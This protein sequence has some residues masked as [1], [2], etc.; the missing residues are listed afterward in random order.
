MTKKFDKDSI[1]ASLFPFLAVTAAIVGGAFIYAGA[2]RSP[3]EI[4]RP[5]QES[6]MGTEARSTQSSLDRKSVV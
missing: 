1:A 6:M 2:N 5:H 4:S 3:V